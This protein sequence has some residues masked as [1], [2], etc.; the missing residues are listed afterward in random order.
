[1]YQ[2]KLFWIWLPKLQNVHNFYSYFY[3]CAIAQW[4]A[5]ASLVTSYPGPMLILSIGSAHNSCYFVDTT[6]HNTQQKLINNS[7]LNQI[8]I[9]FCLLL[10]TLNCLRKNY[11]IQY[12]LWT[13]Y[14][15]KTEDLCGEKIP[16]RSVLEEPSIQKMK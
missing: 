1:M 4:W 16:R 13:K 2:Y 7:V 9:V 8:A 10:C 5:K 6:R 11:T 3:Y 15:K 12:I 14:N